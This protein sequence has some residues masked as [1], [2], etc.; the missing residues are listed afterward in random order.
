[1]ANL[2]KSFVCTFLLFIIF[3]I[4]ASQSGCTFPGSPLLEKEYAYPGAVPVFGTIRIEGARE[5]RWFE[6]LA[7][8]VSLLREPMSSQIFAQFRLPK[9]DS[10]H[11][12]IWY[13]LP[14]KYVIHGYHWTATSGVLAGFG[15]NVVGT[16]TVRVQAEFEV[17]RT[18][19]S[20][21]IGTLEIYL[22]E[23]GK[24]IIRDEFDAVGQQ[25]AS[26]IGAQGVPIKALMHR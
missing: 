9:G 16:N 18:K 24:L 12:F 10:R 7:H 13:L 2:K 15:M 26:S 25:R 6:S 5:E 14:G 4:S 19:D 22:L 20:V 17:P 23:K 8:S 21:Y 11:D 3:S 1:M